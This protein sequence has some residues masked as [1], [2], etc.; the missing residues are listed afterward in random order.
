MKSAATSGLR[1]ILIGGDARS[2]V[3]SAALVTALSLLLLAHSRAADAMRAASDPVTIIASARDTIEAANSRWLPAM[4]RGD[5]AAVASD[6]AD[7]GV[8]LTANGTALRGRAAIAARYRAEL[9]EMGQVVGG[10]LTQEGVTVSGGMVYEWGHGWLA[11]Q[12]AGK[13]HVSSGPYFTVWRR[14][15]DGAWR[16]LRNLVL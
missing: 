7:D 10:G 3:L 12:K 5:A 11:F 13:R 14:D 6:Y 16:I 2:A 1:A 9:A 4:E 8:L 15:P